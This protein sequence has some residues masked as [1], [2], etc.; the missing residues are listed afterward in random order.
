MNDYK[1]VFL[2]ICTDKLKT[3]KLKVKLQ[4]DIEF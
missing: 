1:N 2:S 4:Q 3:K